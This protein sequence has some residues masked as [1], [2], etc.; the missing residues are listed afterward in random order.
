MYT[1]TS[2]AVWRVHVHSGRCGG[3]AQTAACDLYQT[4][5]GE[6]YI[7]KKEGPV[8]TTVHLINLKEDISEK[9][10][11][12]DQYPEKAAKLDRRMKET[13]AELGAEERERKWSVSDDI[14]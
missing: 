13:T 5:T 11:L 10:N 2:S 6:R 7:S 1:S 4:E 12:A 3:A 14:H 9:H 8:P